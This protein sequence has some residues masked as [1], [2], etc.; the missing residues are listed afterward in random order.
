MPTRQNSIL[1]LVL[2]TWQVLQVSPT[3]KLLPNQVMVVE[4]TQYPKLDQTTP[5]GDEQSR[6]VHLQ[7]PNRT[8]GDHPHQ[9]VM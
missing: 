4:D 5:G 3:V 9:V 8:T 6:T 1:Q 7:T 2:S